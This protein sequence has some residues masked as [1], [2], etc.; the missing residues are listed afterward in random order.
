MA[1][2][3]NIVPTVDCFTLDSTAAS[4]CSSI[5][6]ESCTHFNGGGVLTIVPGNDAQKAQEAPEFP[7]ETRTVLSLNDN[8]Q[9]M[10]Q[11]CENGRGK[12]PHVLMPDFKKIS[13]YK[14]DHD[15]M[16]AVRIEFVDGTK[17]T[18]SVHDDDVF[19]LEHGISICIAKRILDE[20]VRNSGHQVYNKL[21]RRAAKF[22]AK[23]QKAEQREKEAKAAEKRS[24]E[25]RKLKK[26]RREERMKKNALDAEALAREE[27]IEIQKEAF[28]RAIRQHEIE[29]SAK[30]E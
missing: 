9:L 21:V 24:E 14:D 6:T 3:S 1:S 2:I 17:T 23:Q 29:K 16:R 10:V 8:G 30:S 7:D 5:C 15:N 4:I 25:N 11:R 20:I 19:S 12:R 26:L 18:A 22:Y 27:I 13:V 28:L